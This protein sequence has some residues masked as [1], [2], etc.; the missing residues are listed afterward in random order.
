MRN[1]NAVLDMYPMAKASTLLALC[2]FALVMNSLPAYLGCIVVFLVIAGL[3]GVL[4][5]Y[6][7]TLLRTVAVLGFFMFL[8]ISIT[9]D[10]EIL[11]AHVL[12]F[13]VY[14]EGI[15]RAI[16]LVA[17]IAL[18]CGAFI[19]F[20]RIAPPREISFILSR[21]GLGPIGVYVVESTFQ[22]IPE[23]RRRLNVIM[24]AQ[25]CRGLSFE[26][27]ALTRLRK[28]FPALMPLVLSSFY[29]TEE[30]TLVLEARGISIPGRK[31]RLYAPRRTAVDA[32]IAWG[33]LAI[34][35]GL[36]L[37]RFLYA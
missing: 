18:L 26:G 14:Q 15:E 23:M 11:L 10:G 3:A 4:G 13:D 12:V 1:K 19:L 27:N 25:Q 8:I 32:V 37:W 31:R 5:G 33:G 2:V 35:V 17:R 6:A 24:D 28:T 34:S 30:K 36:V 21:L 16:L 22:M 29:T 20:S 7:K 9:T